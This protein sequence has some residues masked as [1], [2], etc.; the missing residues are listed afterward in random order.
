LSLLHTMFVTSGEEG[1]QFWEN[2]I[3]KRIEVS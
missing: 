2:V 3:V 1:K